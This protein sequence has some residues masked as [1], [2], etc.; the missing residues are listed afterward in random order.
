MNF[1]APDFNTLKP[2]NL[3]AVEIVKVQYHLED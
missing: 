3:D 2:A 1:I